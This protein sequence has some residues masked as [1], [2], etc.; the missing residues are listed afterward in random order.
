MSGIY[1]EVEIEDMHFDEQLQVYTYPCPCGDKF[2]IAL[3]K[4]LSN[5]MIDGERKQR[6]REGA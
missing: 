1:D 3:V 2:S 5:A 4:P 6:E